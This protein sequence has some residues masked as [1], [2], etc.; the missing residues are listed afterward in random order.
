[1]QFNEAEKPE[2]LL[3]S[4][5]GNK[6]FRVGEAKL[7]GNLLLTT[8]RF[9]SLEAI[10]FE[11]INIEKLK[12]LFEIEEG[13]EIIIFGTGEIIKMVPKGIQKHLVSKKIAFDMMDTGAAA[14]TFNVLQMEGRRV[15]AVLI[16]VE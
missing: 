3:I 5:Y 14:R 13:I 2:L 7:E 1:M 15:A 8:K 4:G 9:Y 10:G 12:P 16:A 6:N 11:D